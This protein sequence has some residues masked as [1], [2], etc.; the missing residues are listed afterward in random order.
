MPPGWVAVVA[1]AVLGR[2]VF[3]ETELH[4]RY[5]FELKWSS[6][7]PFSIITAI[8]E[9]LGLELAPPRRDLQYLIAESAEEPTTW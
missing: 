9:Q 3:D 6:K 4:E 1:Q 2:P 7:N 5:D 8:R